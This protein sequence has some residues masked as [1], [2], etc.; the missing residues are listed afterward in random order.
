MDDSN[1]SNAKRIMPKERVDHVHV[2]LLGHFDPEGQRIIEDPYYG[3]MEEFEVNF[4]Q[5]M[6]SCQALLDHILVKKLPS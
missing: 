3:G 6:R 5:C 1:L 4:Q 2:G